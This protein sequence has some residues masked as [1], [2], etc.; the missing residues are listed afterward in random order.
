MN[1]V[2]LLFVDDEEQIRK[3]TKLYLE[4]K[5]SFV[6]DEAPNGDTALKMLEENRYDA[7][8]SDY[9]M[10]GLNGIDLLKEIRKVSKI[11]FIIFTGRGRE[12][13]AMD[14][15]NCGADY[16][17]QKGGDVASLFNLL[18]NQIKKA[19]E[20]KKSVEE[21]MCMLKDMEDLI[22]VC[23]SSAIIINPDLSVKY[24]NDNG[25]K[26]YRDYVG[27][28]GVVSGTKLDQIFPED[29]LNIVYDHFKKALNEKTK[30]TRNTNINGDPLNIHITP[31]FNP[32]EELRFYS[33]FIENLN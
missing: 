27:Y 31:H 13:V 4:T 17:L 7:V 29:N 12:E 18:A 20:F 33:V 14:A 30:I 19:V 22:N 5:F 11:P 8:L 32:V 3:V 15:L 25:M 16:Y 10:P 2:R 24:I 21:N 9:E 28:F 1:S 23:P 6:V 26:F